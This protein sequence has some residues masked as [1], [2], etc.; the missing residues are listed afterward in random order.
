MNFFVVHIYYSYSLCF[1]TRGNWW[2]PQE[3]KRQH[4]SPLLLNIIHFSFFLIFYTSRNWELLQTIRWQQ[5]SSVVQNSPQYCLLFVLV[6]FYTKRN[7]RFIYKTQFFPCSGHVNTAIWNAP[8]MNEKLDG[9][10]TRM[11]RAVLNK[12]ER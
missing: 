6:G 5:V 4:V 9:N 11:L 1:H 3:I 2:L 12:S 8:G 10:Y 7:R